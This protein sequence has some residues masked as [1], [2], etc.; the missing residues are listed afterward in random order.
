MIVDYSKQRHWTLLTLT[1][2]FFFSLLHKFFFFL[3]SFVPFCTTVRTTSMEYGMLNIIQTWISSKLEFRNVSKSSIV[4]IVHSNYVIFK[5]ISI[6]I[7]SFAW[8]FL[9]IFGIVLLLVICLF[10][11]ER[12]CVIHFWW[13]KLMMMMMMNNSISTLISPHPF[14]N[15]F[16]RWYVITIT[17]LVIYCIKVSSLRKINI[18]MHFAIYIYV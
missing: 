11:Y 5:L 9:F 3:H 15:C 4:T 14:N 2:V 8:Y 18:G 10:I 17:L 1:V 6:A 13:L 16:M 7:P 12:M